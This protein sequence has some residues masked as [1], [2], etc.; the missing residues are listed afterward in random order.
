MKAGFLWLVIF[1][2][3]ALILLFGVRAMQEARILRQLRRAGSDAEAT[4][5]RRWVRGTPRAGNT[6]YVTY[7]Y[8]HGDQSYQHEEQVG[9]GTYKAWLVGTKIPSHTVSPQ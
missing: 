1:L 7:R 3:L 5:I 8:H 2:L 6:Y 4:V 9:S